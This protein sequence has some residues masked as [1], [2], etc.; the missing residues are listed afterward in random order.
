[1]PDQSFGA[2]LAHQREQHALVGVQ[3]PDPRHLDLETAIA[4]QHPPES[5]DDAN[6][7]DPFDGN[8]RRLLAQQ[9]PT[10]P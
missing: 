7:L 10:V 4:E 3:S 8:G 5:L 1:L 2:C 9:T 6:R